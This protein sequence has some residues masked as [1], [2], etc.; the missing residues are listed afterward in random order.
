MAGLRCI[1]ERLSNRRVLRCRKS[2][3]EDSLTVPMARSVLTNAFSRKHQ[4]IQGGLYYDSLQEPHIVCCELRCRAGGCDLNESY[5]QIPV[6]GKGK[7]CHLVGLPSY[8]R[9]IQPN[10]ED[11]QICQTLVK[12]PCVPPQD[13][14]QGIPGSM[15]VCTPVQL[16]PQSARVAR[17]SSLKMQICVD[18]PNASHPYEDECMLINAHMLHLI[19]ET[20]LQLNCGDRG[21]AES[22][23]MHLRHEASSCREENHH[24]F[25][26][27]QRC[28]GH[29]V[30]RCNPERWI[31][32]AKIQKRKPR[33]G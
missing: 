5:L 10:A 27:C 18:S 16:P 22:T 31:L 11:K 14:E 1:S 8:G 21:I 17:S 29:Q 25:K 26:I 20:S 7:D 15:P 19:S 13:V 6:A 3:E 28:Q 30:K 2:A 4:S 12:L 23:G 24:C 33:Q 32:V 9:K